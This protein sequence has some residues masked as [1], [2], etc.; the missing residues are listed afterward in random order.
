M[1][2][3]IDADEGRRD[4]RDRDLVL[5]YTPYCLLYAA[6]RR[7]TFRPQTPLFA[8]AHPLIDAALPIHPGKQVPSHFPPA[9]RLWR[10][11]G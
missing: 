8:V 2:E 11:V 7:S 5:S 1:K 10:T 9:Q 6:S 4:G 3:R